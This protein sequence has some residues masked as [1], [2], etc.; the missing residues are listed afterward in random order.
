MAIAVSILNFGVANA[1]CIILLWCFQ[2]DVLILSADRKTEFSIN[3]RRED[4]SS[5][6]LTVRQFAC[7]RENR[8]WPM[9]TIRGILYG[10]IICPIY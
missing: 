4:L 10:H 9:L 8:I 2:P 7:L 1:P 6:K 5:L 3:S